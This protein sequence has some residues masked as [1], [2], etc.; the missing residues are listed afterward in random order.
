VIAQTG[1]GVVVGIID[2]G[3]DFRHADFTVP[4]SNGQSTRIKSL[5]DMTVYNPVTVTVGGNQVTID[6]DWNYTL[7]GGNVKIGRLYAASDINAALQTAKPS[8]SAD[9]VKERDHNGHGTH[10][11]GIAAG[12]GLAAPNA[13]YAGMA[14]EAD[15]VLVKT[16]RQNDGTDDFGSDDEINALQFIQQKAG[17]LGEPFVINMSLGGQLG[18]HD[19]LAPEERVIDTITASPGRAVCVAAGNDGNDGIHAKAVVPSGGNL[20]LNLHVNTNP[21]FVDLYTTTRGTSTN[22]YTVTVTAPDGTKLGPVAYTQ[23]GFNNPPTENSF[24]Q[25]FNAND[26]KGDPNDTANFQP[27]IF[28]IFKTNAPVGDWKILLQD[29]GNNPNPSAPFDAWATGDDLLFTTFRDDA[30]HLVST[31]ATARG[32]VAVGAFVTR[33]I[34][35]TIGAAAP[36]TSPGPT[37]DGRQK[38]E[39][40]APGYY[41]YSSKSSDIDPTNG[42]NPFTYGTGSNA[43][44]SGV[45]PAKYGGLAGTSMSTPVVTGSLALLLQARPGLTNDQMKQAIETTAVHDGFTGAGWDPH[46]GNGKLNIAAAISSQSS[47]NAID[48]PGFFVTQQ[49]QDFL[50]RAPDQAGLSYWTQQITNCGSNT[51]CLN[52]QRI[53]VSAAFYISVEFQQSGAYVYRFYV[54]SFGKQPTYG[55]FTPD[56]SQVVGGANLE[57]S[58]AQFADNWVARSA[59]TTKYPSSLSSTAFVNNVLATLKQADGVDLSSQS[60]TYVSD[61]NSGKTRGAVLREIVE[62]QAFVNAE[63]NPSFVLMQYFGYL[64]RDADLGGYNFWLNVLN[65]REPNNFTGMVC[66]FITSSEYQQ[67]FG[68]TISHS[69]KDCN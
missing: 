62:N 28:L 45:D 26:D 8:Q 3:I 15:M 58:K 30:S 67:R 31:P 66:A 55:Q 18:P 12:N 47:A 10:V 13:I 36:F 40:S 46:F 41:T 56:R 48:D 24:L 7:P 35:Q 50:G 33:S 63:F 38:P 4:G 14:P 1:R 16:S 43:L 39:I 42:I 52:S 37:A 29:A 57:T 27:D 44:A 53:A 17:E 25:L 65:N 64:R 9:A 34:S 68:T 54:A 61:L 69:N 6:R 59:F 11:T 20:T 19:G 5:L 2:T 60:S 21:Q 23:D 32:A 51:A 22:K 49:Y